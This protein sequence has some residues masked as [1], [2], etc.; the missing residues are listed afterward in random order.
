MLLGTILF[1]I[2]FALLLLALEMGKRLFDTKHFTL[3][4]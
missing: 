3:F 1:V 2:F 4:L